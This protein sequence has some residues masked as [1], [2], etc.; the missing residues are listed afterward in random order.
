MVARG[1]PVMLSMD[2]A[3]A[4]GVETRAVAQ[5][6]KRRSDA[7]TIEHAFQLSDEEFAFLRSQGVISTGRGGVRYRPWALSQKGVM[8]LGTILVSPQANR[9]TDLMIDL[10]LEVNAQLARGETRITVANAGPYTNTQSNWADLDA[11]RKRLFEAVEDLLATPIGSTGETTVRDEI[12]DVG[13]AALGHLKAALQRKGVEN[14]KI[15]AETMKILAETQAIHDRRR[16]E[17]AR[18][19]VDTER[20]ALENLRIKIEIAERVLEL[21]NR[22]GPSAAV[23]LL[24]SF[25]DGAVLEIPSD[26]PVAPETDDGAGDAPET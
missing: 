3:A 23:R 17:V 24:P 2:V 12:G 5:A 8:R 22:L 26:P 6:I 14:E 9:A 4:F 10:F 16:A 11:L 18:A 19:R 15:I 1:T 13:A 7:F 20:V 25:Q 21:T